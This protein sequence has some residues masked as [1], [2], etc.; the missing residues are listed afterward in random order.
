MLEITVNNPGFCAPEEPEEESLVLNKG[1]KV[2]EGKKE[3][4]EVLCLFW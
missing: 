1:V 2:K 3:I 4:E